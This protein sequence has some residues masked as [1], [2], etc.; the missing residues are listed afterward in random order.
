MQVDLFTNFE[1]KRNSTKQPAGGT[2][3]N[4]ILKE[5]CS[6]LRPVIS[7]QPFSPTNPPDAYRYAY[8]PLFSRYYWVDDWTWNDGLWTATL[9]VDVLA[10]YKTQIG[11]S[12]EYI[13]RTDSD[14]NNFDGAISDGM[15]PATTDFSIESVAFQNPFI[16][17]DHTYDGTYV[18]GIISGDATNAVGAITY[19]AMTSAEFGNLRSTLFGPDGLESMNL[20]DALQQWTSTDISE[21]IFKTMYN[22][23]QYI[24][25]CTWFPVNKSSIAGSQQSSI[26]IGWWTFNVSGMRMTSTTGVFTEAQQVP[27]HPQ[28]V[29]RGK[30]LNYAPYTKITLHGKYGSLPI[31]TEYLEVGDY[32]VGIYTLDYVT[33]QCLYECFISPNSAG[34]GRKLIKKTEFLIGVPLQLAQI[35]RDYLGMTVS[36]IDAGKKG[37]VGAIAGGAVAGIPGAIVGAIASGGGAIYDTIANSMPQLQTSGINGSYISIALSTVMIVIH[38]RVVDENIHHKGR[39][40]CKLRQISSLSGFVMCAEGDIDL[41]AY[42]SER[43]KVSKFLVEGFFWE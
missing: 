30:Y 22:P 11:A 28:A 38:F 15:Y 29:T 14:T 23:Y 34:T 16:D 31:D 6:I 24:A 21:G 17:A 10:T 32:I 2:S 13:L 25:S 20:V 9:D 26:Q 35:G 3:V 33:G 18:V 40:L 12:T 1:K 7:F 4:G 43:T 42:D 19:W 37:A 39:P 41:N 36:A 5:P 8:I 27:P